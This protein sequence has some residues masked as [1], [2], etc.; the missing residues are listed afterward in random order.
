[1]GSVEKQWSHTGDEMILPLQPHSRDSKGLELLCLGAHS[2]DLEIGCSGTVLR[3]LREY[4]VHRINWIVF[5]G[6]GERS[7]EA[8]R[9]AERV[10]GG[11]SEL[12]LIQSEFR[13]GYFPYHGSELKE[14]FERLKNEVN[15]DIILT[16]YREDRHQDHRLVSE[17]TY[18]TF[19]NHLILEYE[20]FKVDGDIGNPNVYVPLEKEIVDE[21]IKILFEVFRTQRNRKWFDEEVFHSLLR[22]RGAEVNSY[23]GFAEAFYSRKLVI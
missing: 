1:M 4:P 14:L 18:N 9:G 23:S 2:D 7:L 5:S 12:R 21:K 3:L 10:M 15:P 19:R 20:V 16:H 13:D 17:L 6:T 8:R 11:R 22:L